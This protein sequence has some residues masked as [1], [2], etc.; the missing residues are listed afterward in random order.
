MAHRGL[1]PHTC[2]VHIGLDGG[3]D[4][5]KV[6]LT[7]TDRLLVEETGRS[8]YSQVGCWMI[9][10][11][12]DMILKNPNKGV[13]KYTTPMG[14]QKTS[15][16]ISLIKRMCNF[17]IYRVLPRNRQNIHLWRSCYFLLLYQR[18]LKITIMW[19][20]FWTNWA[21]KPLNLQ[22]RLMWKCVS[23]KSVILKNTDI[24]ICFSDDS[25]R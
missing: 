12:F 1:N 14:R 2:D 5:L 3:Q 11:N 17:Q 25:V 23:V 15:L 9:S 16:G 22:F 21:S 7:V 8:R 6:G 19:R 18:R 20:L 13:Q 24:I 4:I 10:W